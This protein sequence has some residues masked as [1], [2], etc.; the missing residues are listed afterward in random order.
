ML[1]EPFVHMHMHTTC[2]LRAAV[3]SAA[4]LVVNGIPRG[5][6][7]QASGNVLS[8]VGMPSDNVMAVTSFAAAGAG[9]LVQAGVPATVVDQA[10]GVV[11]GNIDIYSTGDYMFTPAPAFVGRVPPVQVT[12]ST[13]NGQSLTV[14]LS[15][16]VNPPLRDAAE[17]PSLAVNSTLR[18]NVLDNVVAPPGAS[19]ALTAFALPGSGASFAPSSTPVTVVDPLTSRPAGT[20]VVLPDGALTFTP[21]S[22]Y[23]GQVPAVTYMVTCSDGQAIPGAFNLVVQPGARACRPHCTCWTYV[24]ACM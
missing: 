3:S 2:F 7:Q 5:P 16:R 14:L 1:S 11:A 18:L 19:V 12:V 15:L 20:L 4:A 6:G 10:T 22:G 24:R 21:A 23:A 13:S 9:L 17:S 8:A